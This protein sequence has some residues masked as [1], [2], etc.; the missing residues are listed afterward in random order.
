MILNP[1]TS[2][3]VQMTPIRTMPRQP[4]GQVT[5]SVET[6]VILSAD[7]L[8]CSISALIAARCAG[9]KSTG[10]CVGVGSSIV[11]PSVAAAA[12]AQAVIAIAKIIKT[13]KT[14][15]ILTP[16]RLIDA[17]FGNNVPKKCIIG[18]C[19]IVL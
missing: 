7:R 4:S 15:L 16:F 5:A 11:G 9:V 17:G 6:N 1:G 2:A 18:V 19:V 14:L 12:G 10:I 13:N 3:C 8:S